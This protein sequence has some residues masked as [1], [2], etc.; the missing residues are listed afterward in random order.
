MPLV[1]ITP[2]MGQVS[3]ASG[4][5]RSGPLSDITISDASEEFFEDLLSDGRSPHPLRC[6]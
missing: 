1:D 2:D 6:R 3:F 5:H 4:S